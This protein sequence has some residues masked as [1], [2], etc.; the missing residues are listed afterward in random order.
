MV[1]VIIPVYNC[2]KYIAQAIESVLN[3]TTKEEIEILVIDDGSKDKT[4]QIVQKYMD[5]KSSMRRV[6]FFV[7]EK[8]LGVAETRNQGIRMAKGEYVAFLDADDWWDMNKLEKQLV[9]IREKNAVLVY[10]GRELMDADGISM[11][12]IVNIPECVSYQALL[13]S[14]YI[15]CSSV[16]MLTKTAKEFYMCH[17]ELH[18]DYIFWL[19]I[20][21]KYK[22][23][24][25]INEPLLKS[26][27][28]AGGK[29]RNKLKSA[30]MHYG[31]Y[32]YMGIPVWKAVC[33]FLCYVVNGV[34]KYR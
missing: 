11:R 17:D 13:R 1:S 10:S 8:N 24:Y 30:R 27:L 6:R 4:K 28:S 32:R 20:L 15:P 3:Q 18:E 16:L 23:A 12:K 19:R 21:K 25:G 31:V 33:L 7:N 2:E 22:Y 29:S 5:I 14:N 9:L 26:R 34:R